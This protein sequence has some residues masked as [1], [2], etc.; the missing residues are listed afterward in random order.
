MLVIMGMLGLSANY[1]GAVVCLIVSKV[2]SLPV[3]Y[4]MRPTWAIFGMGIFLLTSIGLFMI[5]LYT[6]GEL[7]YLSIGMGPLLLAALV[8][9]K[10]RLGLPS[11]WDVQLKIRVPA[12]EEP[13]VVVPAGSDGGSGANDDDPENGSRPEGSSVD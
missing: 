6:N 1:T 5:A 7:P 2:G 3:L 12:K 4:S 8:I 11:L 10:F 13:V 9:R